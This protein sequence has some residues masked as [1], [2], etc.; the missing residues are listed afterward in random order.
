MRNSQESSEIELL[1]SWVREYRRPLLSFFKKRAPATVEPE[2]LVQ[3]V[4]VRLT[5]R[6]NLASIR[7]V[8]GYLFQTASSV[9]AD[10]FRRDGVRH[11]KAHG[12]FEETE[13]SSTAFSPERVVTGRDSVE[14][15]VGEIRRMPDRMQSVFVLYHFENVR[16][17]DIARRLK[18]GLSTVEKDIAAANALLLKCDRDSK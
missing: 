10:R 4:F 9:L 12:P 5:R 2:D 13:H 17:V 7:Q 16:Q 15:L 11:E 3:E 18:M 1:D 6:A 14:H 8:E